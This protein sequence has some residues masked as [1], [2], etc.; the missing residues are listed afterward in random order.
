[1]QEGK[2]QKQVGALLMEELSGIFQRLGLS[3]IDGG[4]ISL[5]AVKVT[6]DLLE[7][8]V[9]LS[10][11]QAKDIPGTMKKIE[12]RAWEIKRELAARVKHQLRRIPTL[13]Y[14]H[15]DT[16][17]HADKMEELFRKIKKDGPQ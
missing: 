1:M 2:R 16:L 3:M 10:L 9:Y 15:D 4:L 13:S 11:F 5:T 6:P 7:A 12:E 14:F 8:R 17:D